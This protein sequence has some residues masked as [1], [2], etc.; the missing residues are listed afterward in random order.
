MKTLLKGILAGAAGTTLLNAATYVD[1]ALTGRA[2][3]A[4]P[5]ESVRKLA[6]IF[7]LREMA[8]AGDD[9]PETV[10]NTR[11]ALGALLG[12][13]VGIGIGVLFGAAYPVMKG[14]PLLLQGLLA[15]AAA[16]AATDLGLAGLAVSDPKTWTPSDWLRDAVPHLCYGLAVAGVY[17]V[18]EA[19]IEADEPAASS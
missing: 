15:G 17:A 8:A 3:S 14:R 18:F 1:M 5:A 6:E 9:V 11:E 13:K 10:R 16:M 2:A 4:V 7:G 19:A 12:I